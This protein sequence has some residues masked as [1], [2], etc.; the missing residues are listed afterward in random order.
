[1]LVI[2]PFTT[3]T[4]FKSTVVNEPEA[5]VCSANVPAVSGNVKILGVVKLLASKAASLFASLT[6][7]V[8]PPIAT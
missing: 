5:P 3:V 7:A 6:P 8:A 2:R 1:M 4:V